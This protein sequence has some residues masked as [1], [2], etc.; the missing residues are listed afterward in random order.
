MCVHGDIYTY[1][2][3]YQWIDGRTAGSMLQEHK[4]I[5]EVSKYH[6]QV[7]AIQELQKLSHQIQWYGAVDNK[8]TC[9]NYRDVEDLH[10]VYVYVCTC[11]YSRSPKKMSVVTSQ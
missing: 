5:V 1:V 3:T 11:T 6:I 9:N 4:M 2:R 7:R 8:I 10:A